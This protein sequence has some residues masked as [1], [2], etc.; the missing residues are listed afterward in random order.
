MRHRKIRTAT[1]VLL[2]STA[3]SG[4]MAQFDGCRSWAMLSVTEKGDPSVCLVFVQDITDRKKAE[5]ELKKIP[6]APGGTGG[7]TYS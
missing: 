7:R 2:S 1:S 6:R 5:E 4:R 3:L